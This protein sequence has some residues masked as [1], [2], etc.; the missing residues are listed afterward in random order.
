MILKQFSVQGKENRLKNVGNVAASREYFYQQKPN[1]LFFLLKNR[2][3]WMNEYLKPND[4]VL[5][6]GCG[7]GLSKE[8]L[9]KDITL[10]LSDVEN[11]PWINQVVDALDTKYPQNYFDAVF[12]SNMIHHLAFPK[13]FFTEMERILKPGGKLLIQEINCSILCRI[14]LRILRHEGWSFNKDPFSLHEPA[15]EEGDPWSGNNAIPNLLFDNREKFEAHNPGWKISHHQF[16]ECMIFP[17]SGGV[18]AKAKT[19]NLP[20]WV[21]KIVDTIDKG[22]IFIS[23]QLFALQRRIVLEKV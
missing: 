7:M 2:Y 15:N 5:E 16:S 4:A 19:I 1:N 12:C 20:F 13:K 8:F 10:T 3:E 11:H 21:L 18:T 6:V 23:P 14:M 9:R 22:L 17:L